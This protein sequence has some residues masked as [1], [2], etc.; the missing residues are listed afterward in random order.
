MAIITATPAGM[1]AVLALL[2]ATVTAQRPATEVR[3][4]VAMSVGMAMAGM[5]AAAGCRR[6]SLLR[7]GHAC[8]PQIAPATATVMVT[9]TTVVVDTATATATGYA[10]V[11]AAAPLI[12]Y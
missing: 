11:P 2:P 7:C 12:G 6:H 10:R 1:V 4:C 3:A 5:A 8:R 9:A